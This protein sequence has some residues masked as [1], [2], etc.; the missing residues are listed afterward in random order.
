MERAEEQ[1]TG[2]G[3]RI[4]VLFTCKM[5]ITNFASHPQVVNKEQMKW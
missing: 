4:R 2:L 3:I 1:N 5:R